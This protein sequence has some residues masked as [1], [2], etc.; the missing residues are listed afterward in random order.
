[1]QKALSKAGRQLLRAGGYA[2]RR[3][4]SSRWAWCVG[5]QSRVASAVSARDFFARYMAVSAS[6]SKAAVLMPGSSGCADADTGVDAEGVVGDDDGCGQRCVHPLGHHAGLDWCCAGEDGGELVAAEA[7]QQV[8]VAHGGGQAG[9]NVDEER[10]AD[11]MSVPVVD[12]L[13]SVEID[14]QQGDRC[15]IGSREHAGAVLLQVPTVGQGGERVGAG[16]AAGFGQ[17]LSWQG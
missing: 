1:M 5:G 17:G 4:R 7:A 10:V 3:A 16:L 12:D 9:G 8:V 14:H 13:E 15:G 6:W 2:R 11:G